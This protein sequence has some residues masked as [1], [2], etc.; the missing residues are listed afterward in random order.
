MQTRTQRDSFGERS[1]ILFSAMLIA[2]LGH[3]GSPCLPTGL[4]GRAVQQILIAWFLHRPA[5]S[6]DSVR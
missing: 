5:V 2:G 1:V 3:I 4:H 6:G